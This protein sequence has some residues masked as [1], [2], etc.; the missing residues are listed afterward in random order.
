MRHRITR[1]LLPL[2]LALVCTG[3]QAGPR[4]VFIGDSVTDGAWGRSGGDAVPSSKRNQT[5]LNHIYGHSYMMLCAAHLQS[6]YP[7]DG[8]ECFNRGIS[9]DG[10][11]H[12]EAR[13]D[14]DVI[15]LH[16]D[17]LSILIGT[18]DVHRYLEGNQAEP[19]DL[20]GWERRYRALLDRALE[21]NPQTDLM[22][23]TPFVAK[24]GR[25]G[26]SADFPV[27]DSLVSLLSEAVCRIADD[28]GATLLRYDQ[29]FAGLE[30]QTS[31]WIWDGIHPTPAGH[32]RMA[33]LWISRCE[34]NCLLTP[35]NER[36]VTAPV[37]L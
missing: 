19:F 20:P 35:R 24:V 6:Q 34:G 36:R 4:I 3:V 12:L 9:G 7:N 17:V 33:D 37:S 32:K 30:G 29:L 18:N 15:D 16:P 31:H 27:R 26:N 25:V 23:G 22:L 10:L 11:E 8:I 28:Y 1:I 14:E 21:A 2:A 5:D 13:W